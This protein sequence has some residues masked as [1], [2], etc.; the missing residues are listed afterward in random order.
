MNADAEKGYR[1]KLVYAISSSGKSTLAERDSNV[2]DG[3]SFLYTTLENFFPDKNERTRLLH[4]KKLC[5]LE[6]TDAK[7]ISLRKK[8][9]TEYTRRFVDALGS[10][11]S[12]VITSVID[13]PLVYDKYF[14]YVKGNYLQ[15]LSDS[16]RVI[17]NLQSEKDNDAL[18]K[19]TP[20]IRLPP[21]S[22]LTS[23]DLLSVCSDNITLT[24]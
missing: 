14:G 16:G 12:C 10:G 6:T 4:W 1:L 19:Y 3:D 24:S 17:D 9:R 5:R 23:D 21:G 11:K 13:L 7:I 20:L 2:I 22:Y 8:V 18:D 15:H